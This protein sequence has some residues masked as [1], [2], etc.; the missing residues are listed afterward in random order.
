MIVKNLFKIVKVW[1]QLISTNFYH[2]NIFMGCS[3]FYCRFEG[4]IEADRFVVYPFLSDWRV[5]S[6]RLTALTKDFY[7]L[8]D[9][10]KRKMTL[11]MNDGLGIGK[12]THMSVVS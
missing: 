2:E 3:L 12:T 4:C 1:K 5:P 11:K 6:Y 8:I 9:D 7:K 10:N